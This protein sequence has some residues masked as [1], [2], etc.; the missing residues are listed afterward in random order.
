MMI[1]Q[2]F[3]QLF[4]R[5][6]MEVLAESPSKNRMAVYFVEVVLDEQMGKINFISV[7]SVKGY[8]DKYVEGKENTSGTPSIAL[9]NLIA[10]YLDYD[11]FS[12]FE[13]QNR[14]V[15]I[16]NTPSLWGRIKEEKRLIN[17]FLFIGIGGALITAVYFNLSPKRCWKWNEN[18]YIRVSCDQEFSVLPNNI[19]N[20]VTFKRIQVDRNTVFFSRGRALVWYAKSRN[21]SIEYF[22]D[23]G[24]HPITRKELKPITNYIISKYVK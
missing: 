18:T 22:N 7:K 16:K 14:K 17:A 4:N 1:S 23:R 3:T 8:Y 2:L 20:P 11:G 10:T 15:D 5:L 12:D 19:L 24:L 13:L 6:K 21:G 9:C